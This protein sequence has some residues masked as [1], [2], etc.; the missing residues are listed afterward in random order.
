M[1]MSPFKEQQTFLNYFQN[2]LWI[3]R[4]EK[5][6]TKLDKV[7]PWESISNTTNALEW[8]FGY[9]KVKVNLHRGLKKER[10]IKLILVLI[11]GKN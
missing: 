9:L 11:H 7:V 3:T 10:K 5:F 1:I 2:E 8:V 6:L 4:T